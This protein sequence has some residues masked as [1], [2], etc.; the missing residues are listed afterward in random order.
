MGVLCACM[1]VNA[2]LDSAHGSQKLLDP[3]TGVTEGVRFPVFVGD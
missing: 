3:G 2:C 1:P